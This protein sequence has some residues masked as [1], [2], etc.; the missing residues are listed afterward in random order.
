MNKEDYFK[1]LKELETEYKK[2][3]RQ[4]AY[5][6]ALANNT[7]QIDDIIQGNGY[8][9]QVKKIVPCMPSLSDEPECFYKGTQLKKDLK[10]MKRQDS[11]VSVYQSNA[12]I[13]KKVQE[14]EQ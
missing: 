4:L 7:I 11:S 12:K 2:S 14:N 13:I 3:I 5:D 10:P 1:R 6:Y 9:I 8:I